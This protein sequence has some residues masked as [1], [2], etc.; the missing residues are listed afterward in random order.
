MAHSLSIAANVG[1]SGLTLKGA[2]THSGTIHTSFRDIA[3]TEIGQGTYELASA[4]FPSG[5]RGVLVAYTGTLGVA[6]NFSGVTVLACQ[7]INPETVEF[8]DV[9]TSSIETG[10]GGSGAF[11]ITVTVTDGTDVL[12]NANVRVSAG[13]DTFVQMTDASGNAEFSLDAGDYEVTITKGGYSFTPETRTVTGS[14]TGTLTDDLEMTVVAIVPPAD[15]EVCTVYGTLFRPNGDEAAD[16]PVVATLVVRG[17]G[18]VKAN[19]VIVNR[20]IQGLTDGDGAFTMNLIRTDAMI[21]RD[22]HWRI[23]CEAAD[24]HK[25]RVHL[26]TPTL[27]IATL[28]P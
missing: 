23:D 14:Q 5:Y 11:P 26:T 18:P 4:S 3:F 8:A 27:D 19:G 24:F 1:E 20:S 17:D 15:P 28:I 7:E 13:I 2:L 22:C 9:L 12:Q 6:S 21:P 25:K 10:G 16:Q